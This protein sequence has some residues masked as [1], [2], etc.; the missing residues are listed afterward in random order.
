MKMKRS[1]FLG[2]LAAA[3]FSMPSGSLMAQQDSVSVSLEKALEI[4]LSDNPTIMVADRQIEI[5]KYYK[6]EQIAAL[7][8]T[9][10]AS[11]SYSRSLK[12]QMISFGG[13]D[14][15]PMGTDNTYNAGF[16]LSL[17]IIAPALWN[18]V[19][20]SEVE[21]SL[22]VEQA[23][24]SRLDMVNQ[25]R[26]AFYQYLLAAES[27]DVLLL[28]YAN[29]ED[30]LQNVIDN[31]EQGRVSEYDKLRT[32]VTLMNLKPQIASAKNGLNL[33]E[34]QLK[35]L[36]GVDVAEPLK[37]EGDIKDYEAEMNAEDMLALTMDLYSDTTAL[38][39]N[40]T[41]LKQFA[42]QQLQLE[43][44]GS[45]IKSQYAPVLALSASYGWMTMNNDFR[46]GSYMW[47]PNSSVGL[48]LQVPIFQGTKVIN[49][50]K[51]N[52]LQQQSLA[53][54]RNDLERQMKISVQSAINNMNTA[55]E[56][57]SYSKEN[58]RQAQKAFELSSER[59]AVGSGTLLDVNDAD[60]ALTQSRL[61][62]SQSIYNYLVAYA[63]L[64]KALGIDYEVDEDV[65]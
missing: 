11:A 7:I 28:S 36:L 52:K 60:L 12:K 44:A 33:A 47:F 14:P 45:V 1:L 59:Y 2:C 43:K 30:N 3:L 32:E 15:I 63:D 37:F 8:P 18:T 64:E 10:S 34:L 22:A 38:L 53:L 41:Q 42:L 48:S 13:G 40:N 24:S 62:Y 58:I 29:M 20:M 16:S 35:V 55:I 21:I 9:V 51:Q 19:K 56:E 23:R 61:S 49:Q 17:P 50:V 54:Q 57:I 39:D 26:K 25:V 65:E 4:A 5:K 6:K 46:I 31:Y 27:Y